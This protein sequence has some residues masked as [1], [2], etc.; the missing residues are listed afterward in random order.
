MPSLECD[1]STLMNVILVVKNLQPAVQLHS[2]L[3]YRKRCLSE[4]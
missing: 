3:M 2:I 1:T 4:K